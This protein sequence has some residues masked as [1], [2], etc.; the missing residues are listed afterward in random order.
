MLKGGV[1]MYPSTEKAPNGKLRLL[2]ECNP[3]A[4][5]AEQAG[6]LA[7]DGENRIM[8]VEPSELHQRIPFFIGSKQMVE[9]AMSH[10]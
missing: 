5:L 7:T 9:E 8:E 10:L 6:G 4:Y 3:L 2:Y 1:Y